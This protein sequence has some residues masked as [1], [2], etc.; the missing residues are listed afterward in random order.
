MSMIFFVLFAIISLLLVTALP[1]SLTLM[2]H[3]PKE[4]VS[5]IMTFVVLAA[6]ELTE[7]IMNIYAF[8]VPRLLNV[9]IRKYPLKELHFIRNA[10][11][12]KCIINIIL[13]CI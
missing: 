4:K 5:V 8:A 3:Y 11:Q 2:G 13:V 10:M 1:F 6:A 7:I 12:L 9:Y